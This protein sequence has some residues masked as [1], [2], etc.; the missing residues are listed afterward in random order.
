[1]KR[2]R[3]LGLVLVAMAG[4]VNGAAAASSPAAGVERAPRP[5]SVRVWEGTLV[6]PT[7]E[8]GKEDPNPPFPL[9]AREHV[10]PYTMLDDLTDR[11][12]PHTY[13]ALFL[14]N[15]FLKATILPDVGGR[16]YS[17]YD[18]VAKREVFYRN[19]VVKYGLVGLRGAW[20]SGGVEFN[21]PDG[22]TVNTISPVASQFRRN[23]DGSATV[24]VGN[25]DWVTRMHWEVALTLHPGEA[26]LEQQVT[27]LNPTAGAQPF[28]YWANAAVPAT[29]DMRFIFPMREAYPH[30]LWPVY[31]YPVHA[32]VDLSWYKNIREPLSL[33][34]RQV[35]RNFFGAYYMSADAGVVHVAD[36]HQV[37]GKKTWSWGVA[38]DG[39]IWTHLLT[40]A[41]GPYNEIQSGRFETQ[42]THEFMPSQ[43]VDRWTEY[44]YPVRGLADGFVEATNRLALN[45]TH[46][47]AGFHLYLYPS[48]ALAGVRVRLR[49]GQRLLGNTTVGALT[50]AHPAVIAFPVAGAAALAAGVTVEVD[51]AGRPIAKWSAAEPVDGNPR[52]PLL[53]G[54]PRPPHRRRRDMSAAE[55]Y[56]AGEGEE[57]AGREPQAEVIYAEV[58]RRDPA[59]VPALRKRGWEELRADHL[60]AAAGW[61]A[62][63]LAHEASDPQANYLAGV[64]ARAQGHP[65]AAADDFWAALRYGGDVASARL[66]LGELALRA[67]RNE[68][69]IGSLQKALL[70]NPDDALARTDLAVALRRTGQTT[71]AQNALA[72]ALAVM[73]L[74]PQ[75]RAEER[76]VTALH[77]VAVED[78]LEVA[79]W[80]R[81]LGEAETADAVLRT[82]NRELP[83]GA[84]SP[85]IGYYLADQ[86]RA[87]GNATAAAQWQR[88]AATASLTGMFPNRREDAA[89]LRRILEWAPQDSHAQYLLGTFYFA[90]GHYAEAAELWRTAWNAGF[91]YPVMARD[92]GLAAWR[93][94]H[95]LPHASQWYEQAIRLDP[96]EFHLYLDLDDIYAAMGEVRPREQLLTGAPAQVQAHDTIQARLARVLI[97]QRQ[98]ARALQVLETHSFR[99]WEGGDPVHGMYVSAKIAM[100]RA[101]LARHQWAAAEAA[102]R[103]AL[104]F[105]VN[106]AVGAPDHPEL[107]EPLFWLSEALAAEGRADAARQIRMQIA[108]GREQDGLPGVY[109]AM[110]LAR[111]G[112]TAAAQALLVRLE[113]PGAAADAQAWYV[114]GLAQE[115][116]GESAQASADYQRALALDPTLWSARI[117]LP[118]VAPRP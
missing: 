47:A 44:W 35:R 55:L 12:V 76:R 41:D 14:E 91:Q 50:A 48:V 93:V 4:L 62:Q 42:L 22:H 1:M 112:Q 30:V 83:V 97:E 85:L 102:F 108:A 38:D 32:G 67:G 53:A 34:G 117:A 17:L 82:A 13:R 18:K 116:Q 45:L 60:N 78:Y 96:E 99:P 101:A 107:Q 86:A 23:R 2:K 72:Q 88:Q 113:T 77:F 19:H 90:H 106:L 66:Q 52:L 80:L 24:V 109:R 61:T 37:P 29:P 63:A 65:R 25:T 100:G 74:L 115:L 16:L 3:V 11:R 57:K 94:Q 54:A 56:A 69:A 84:R 46:T 5:A 70:A 79:A 7:Y 87:Q 36:A 58:L 71:A 20:I 64:I 39:L 26:R 114:G 75:A 89:V 105:P 21:F 111:L 118:R 104:T 110:A 59:F 73:P 103:Q 68:R 31:S 81:R 10:Y 49:T 15:Q 98:Y 6:L 92:L 33:F 8:L 43:R 40:D 51:S 9:T 95:D 27:L 28:W